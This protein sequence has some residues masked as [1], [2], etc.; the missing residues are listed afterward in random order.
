MTVNIPSGGNSSWTL[1]VYKNGSAVSGIS[2]TYTFS[3]INEATASGAGHVEL[4]SY[5]SALY[6]TTVISNKPILMGGTN[7]PVSTSFTQWNA[8]FETGSCS[9]FGGGSGNWYSVI[10]TNDYG[11]FQCVE[12]T[13]YNQWTFSNFVYRIDDFDTPTGNQ[14]YNFSVNSSTITAEKND[15]LSIRFINNSNS[16]PNFTASFDNIGSLYI[17]SLSLSTGYASTDCPYFNSSSM[18]ISSSITG[19]NDVI[20]FDNG[21]SSFYG[22]NYNFIPNP[23]TGS[24][25]ILYSTYGDVDYP[26]TI[27]SQDILIVYL[28]DGTYV[29]SRISEV[30]GGGSSALRIKL[31]APLSPLLRSDLTVGSGAY[32][33]FLILSRI[34]DETS[35]Y[36]IFPKRGGK[37]SY[38][39]IIP[40][41]I[42]PDILTN[43]DTITREVKQKLINEQSAIDNFSGGDF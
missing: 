24:A 41:N 43:I 32:K 23:L 10:G 42:S 17:S 30:I 31:D 11:P 4:I 25:N 6:P 5:Q 20:I 2:D 18:A 16:T 40:N 9:S 8:Y 13:A 21:L 27:K 26:F 3:A 14:T 29:E 12:N 38:G 22:N 19:S 35:A 36:L 28:S 33:S 34:E 7:Y 1:G 37:T 15:N 39:F